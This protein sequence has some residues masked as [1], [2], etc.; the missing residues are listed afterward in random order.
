M[1]TAD[2]VN[3]LQKEGFKMDADSE[4]KL[5]SMV[6]KLLED[7]SNQVQ[8]LVVKCLGPL[9][10]RVKEPQLQEIVDILCTHLLNEKKGGEELRDIASIGLKTVITEMPAEPPTAAIL[11]T[12]RLTPRLIAGV[13][14]ED[15][16]DIVGY[17]L[18]ALNDLLGKFGSQMIADHEK[19]LK[20]VQPQLG[21]K[22][23]TSRKRAIGCLG[24]LAVTIPDQLF[25]D[26]VHSLIKLL[27]ESGSNLD[28][29]RTYIQAIGAISRSV[30]YRLGK[31]LPDICPRIIRYCEDTKF[32][33]DDE[34]RE[35]CFQCF[36]SLILRCPKEISPFLD[37]ITTLCLDFIKYDPNYAAE[38]EEEM[39][40]EEEEEEGEDGDGEEEDYS[41]DDDMSWK[42]RRSSAKCLSAMITTRPELLRDIYS[43][44][45]PILIARFKE[46][47]EN[48]KLDIF[49]T[50]V[51]LMKQTHSIAKRHPE[52]TSL[53]DPLRELVPKVVAGITKQLK[54]KSI[55]TRSGAFSLLKEL[56]IVLR[57]ALSEHIAALVPGIQMSLG[58]KN[59]NS[60][61][62]IEA[63]TFLRLLLASHDPRVFH[64]FIKVIA[65][66]VFKAIRDPYYRISAEGLRVGC[67][68]VHV[69]RP[70][71]VSFDY[72]AY[73]PDLFAA[74][75]DKLKAQDIDQEVKE[76]AITCMGLI[77]AI[78]GDELSKSQLSEVLAILLDRL[79]NEITRLTAVKS[80]ESIANS[81]LHLDLSSILPEA[82]KELSSF[83]RKAN[84]Q[85]KQ[86]SLSTLAVLVKN[87]GT[88]GK[89]SELFKGVLIELAPLISDSDLHLT[90]LALH[91]CTLIV[92]ADPHSVTT[93]A[94]QI[95]PKSLELMKSSL[96]QG[97]ALESLL[98]LFSELVRVNA[99]QLGFAVLLDRL[100]SLVNQKEVPKQV[101][102]NTAKAVAALSLATDPKQ[103]DATIVRFIKDLKS[104]EEPSKH[105]ALY[106]LGEIGRRT[107]LSSHSD[108]HASILSAFDSIN[109]ETRQA[110][111]FAL[112]NVAVGS[113]KTYLPQILEEI[114]RTPRIKYLLIHS[115]REIIVR[116]SSSSDGIEHLRGF[117]SAILPILFENCENEEE[118]TRNVVAE[119]LGKL[120]IVSPKEIVSALSDRVK[121]DSPFT[122]STIVTALKFAI[123]ERSKQ[124]VDQLL[125][126]EMPK[127]L[128]LLRD[129]DL[130]VRRNT[131]LTL[132]Y[133][134]HNKPTLIRDILPTYLPLIYN[135]SKVKP[136]LIREVDLGPFKHK[137]DD[138]LE[139][140]KAA[141]E[142]MYTLLDSC[143]D[144]VDIPAFIFNLVEG[145][146]DHYDIKMLSHLM[147]IRLSS[148]AGPAL[149]EGL[150]QLVE[151]LR[152]TIGTKA[153]EG[154]VKQEVERN[155]ELIRS[156][157]RA[158]VAITRIP[159]VESNLK[160]EEFLKSTIKTG[161]IGEKFTAIKAESDQHEV[162]SSDATMDVS[163]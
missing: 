110:A 42:V 78:L 154:A 48:V 133:A 72:K 76:S 15:K 114:N 50:F 26:L 101:L 2:L 89:A 13:N 87:Y 6:L 46:R 120:A 145:L 117:Q 5:T 153:K 116:Q 97:L 52:L 22:R 60:N 57:G 3:E 159:N 69:L 10:R 135:E 160:F 85:L 141:F 100:L 112:G 44:V 96:L 1:A 147:L 162:G 55:K 67:E 148:V 109:E 28:K 51:D 30:G 19:I 119:C 63:L 56:V 102:L 157:L 45:A 121:S 143:L 12:K 126:P 4:K 151:P 34:L 8:E 90:H 33:T 61:L 105:L 36:E 64:P 127:F 80:L 95:F 83:L 156:S 7:N 122:R 24:H 23:T 14:N 111:S 70:E 82:I 58:D 40:T 155:D 65:G 106:C 139:I 107:D 125:L 103:R 124:P 91:L 9:S 37:K 150:D 94:D 74:T 35:N 118:G 62:K 138:G 43:K 86:S 146:K 99:S 41:D 59:T 128:E 75:F 18:E 132:N 25:T 29:L 98:S 134:A 66:P 53:A 142:C 144:R 16:P 163:S 136:E 152:A 81:R 137:V 149:L 130:N 158:I 84:R 49:A 27:E 68:L 161:E 115:L 92:Q 88:D 129:K 77:L 47:E 11:I 104:K 20:V 17:C 71:G 140:R 73:V 54:E 93:V 108:I 32:S 113:L 123:L 131:L 38:D 21:S 31:F 39:E 79:G